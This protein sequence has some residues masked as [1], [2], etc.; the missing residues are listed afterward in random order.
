MSKIKCLTLISFLLFSPLL[1]IDDTVSGEATAGVLLYEVNPFGGYEGV[2]IFNYGPSEVNLK[3]WSISDGEG[4]LTVAKDIRIGSGSRLTFIKAISADDWFSGRDNAITF[5]DPRIEKKGS[6]IIADAGDDLYLYKGTALIDAVCYGGKGTELG[7]TGDPAR[8]SSGKYLL[9]TGPADTDTLADWIV[10][11][12]GLTNRSFDPD[13]FFDASVI[14][15]SFPESQGGPIFSALEKAEDEVLVSAYLLTSVE[16]TA[17]LCALASKGVAVRVMLEGS[18]LGMDLS[19]ELMLMNALSEAGGEVCLINDPRAGNFERYSYF[20]NKYAVIDRNT[21][22]ITSENWTADNLG[23]GGNRGWGIIIESEGYAEYTRSIFIND[24]DPGYGDVRPL[25]EY[26]SGFH[27]E[28]RPYSGDLTYAGVSPPYE[29][30][31]FD[32]RVMPSF[33]PDNSWSALRH[34]IDGAETRVYSQQM[35]VGSS[36]QTFSDQ[37]PL[38]WMYAAAERGADAK[39]IIDASFDSARVKKMADDINNTSQIKAISKKGGGAFPLIHNKGVIIDDL[40]WIASVNWTENSFMN[41]REA[42]VVIDSADVAEFFADLF[43]TDWGVDKPAEEEEEEKELELTLEEFVHNGE[44][45]YVFIVSGPEISSYEWDVLGD[46]N[47]RRSS[48]NRVICRDLP[49]GTYTMSVRLDGTERSAY[50]LYAIEEKEGPPSPED[51]ENDR[52]WM[53]TAAAIALLGGAG[54]II[55]KRNKGF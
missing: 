15:F 39:I 12:P 54:A 28:I 32:A 43:I 7:W 33:S 30:W 2:S 38:G 42:A 52:L 22:V 17:L 46:G 14:P 10:T 25:L 6:F 50:L 35:D 36:Y 20:H 11:K 40:V 18:V 48:V 34:F 41:N 27:P 37:S 24:A 23:P 4:T 1:F 45:V 3:G 44:S 26:L 29:T 16:L 31:A 21:V 8:L 51:T 9:R 47:I 55:L 5:G 53:A 13:L 19:A 49:V